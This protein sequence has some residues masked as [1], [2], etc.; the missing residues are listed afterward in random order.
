MICGHCGQ[1]ARSPVTVNTDNTS[2]TYCGIPRDGG[3]WS[4]WQQIIR[5]WYWA[6]EPHVK[7]GEEA[8][9]RP[10]VRRVVVLAPLRRQH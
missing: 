2:E 7:E 6:M 3:E 8:N 9:P 5:G 10:L 1:E 4:C